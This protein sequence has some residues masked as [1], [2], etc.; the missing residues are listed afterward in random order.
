MANTNAPDGFRPAQMA[1]GT[2]P[3][4]REYDLASGYS[5]SIFDG[6]LVQLVSGLVTRCGATDKPLGVFAGVKYTAVNGDIVYTNQWT[7]DT[8]T[9]AAANAK[10]LVYPAQDNLFEAQFTGTPTI[11][12]LGDTFTIATTAGSTSTGRSAEGVTTTTTS[13]IMKFVEFSTQPGQSIGQYSRGLF[14]MAAPE[15]A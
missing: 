3:V 12:S 7:A 15:M 9:K 13:G 5:T 14:K 2:S 6:D 1:N 8:V 10:V 11:A 4:L